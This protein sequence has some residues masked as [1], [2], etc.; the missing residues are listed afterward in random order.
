MFHL[1]R[2]I[3]IIIYFQFQLIETKLNYLQLNTLLQTKQTK[4]VQNSKINVK[5]DNIFP[6]IYFNEK[7]TGFGIEYNLLNVISEKFDLTLEFNKNIRFKIDIFLCSF[8]AFHN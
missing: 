1:Y 5:I 6:F 3:F 4:N 7:L 8:F 2:T